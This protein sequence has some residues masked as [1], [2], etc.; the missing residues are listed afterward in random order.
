MIELDTVYKN[1][2]KYIIRIEN[3]IIIAIS[4]HSPALNFC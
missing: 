3:K 1:R 2:I 4:K